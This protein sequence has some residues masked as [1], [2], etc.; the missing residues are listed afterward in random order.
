MKDEQK[1]GGSGNPPAVAFFADVC[2]YAPQARYT[3]RAF[4]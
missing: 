3:F 1:N 4:A 2:Q